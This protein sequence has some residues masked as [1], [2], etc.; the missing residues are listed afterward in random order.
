MLHNYLNVLLLNVRIGLS[1]QCCWHICL[2]FDVRRLN[3]LF[4]KK[5]YYRGNW[6]PWYR[7]ELFSPPWFLELF[8]RSDT[9]DR[10]VK[11][12]GDLFY[13]FCL[14][15]CLFI[16][17]FVCL[18]VCLLV[19]GYCLHILHVYKWKRVVC[20]VFVDNKSR[21]AIL[22]LHVLFF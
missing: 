16:S 20:S 22:V 10:N 15:V 1:Y 21:G 6:Y 17:L 5:S 2:C 11:K 8:V 12:K 13:V 18:F 14:V 4:L 3:T 19:N 7:T 9:G